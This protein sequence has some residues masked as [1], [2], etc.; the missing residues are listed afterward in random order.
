MLGMKRLLN[1]FD[2]KDP[3]DVKQALRNLSEDPTLPPVAQ[4]TVRKL[5]ARYENGQTLKASMKSEVED[6]MR[7]V[8]GAK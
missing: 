4:K 6:M 7:E 2:G 1:K 5:L 3:E 8:K